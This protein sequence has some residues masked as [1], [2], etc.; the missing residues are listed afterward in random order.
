MNI[1]LIAPSHVPFVLGGAERLWHDLCHQI[2]E[3]TSNRADIINIPAPEGDFWEI[4]ESYNT[5]SRLNL[6]HFDMVIS[7]KNPC[8]MVQHP[9]HILYMLHPLRGVYDTYPLFHLPYQVKSKHTLVNKIAAACDAGIASDELFDELN[10]LKR[11][12]DEIIED[13]NIPSPF[14][15]KILHR[16]DSNALSSVKRIYTISNTVTGRAEYFHGKEVNGTLPPPSGLKVREGSPSAYLLTYSRLDQAKRI[17][18]II[19]GFKKTRVNLELRIAGEGPELQNLINLSAGDERIKFLGRLTDDSL[20]DQIAHARA[21]CF[22]PYQEDYG[23]VTIEALFAGKPVI[24]TSDAGGPLDFIV[25]GVN[26]YVA[27]PTPSSIGNAINNISQESDYFSLSAAAKKSVSHVRWDNLIARLLEQN[28]QTTINKKLIGVF[29]TYP[30]YPPKGGGQARVF[31]L[32]KE[33]EKEYCVHVVCLVD[34]SQCEETI[35]ISSNFKI[36][37]IPANKGFSEEDWKMYQSSGIPS[38][39]IVMSYFFDENSR[40][41]EVAKKLIKQADVLVAEQC[42]TYPLIYKYGE[43][44]PKVY[45]S[46]NVEY[47]LKEQMLASAKN[48]DKLLKYVHDAEFSA[49][50]SAELIIYCSKSDEQKMKEVYPEYIGHFSEVVKNGADLSSISYLTSNERKS[51]RHRLGINGVVAIFIASWHEPNIEAVRSL[52]VIAQKTPHIN[53]LIVGTV[54]DYFSN[55]P[56]KLSRNLHFTG[57]VTV[58]EKDILLQSADIAVNPML[59]GSGTNIKMFDYLAAGLPVVSTPVGARGIE[60]IHQNAFVC[61]LDE[62]PEYINRALKQKIKY[63]RRSFIQE[64]YSWKSVG[65]SY[66]SA[67]SKLL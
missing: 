26:G 6:N 63:S 67:I 1:A 43:S 50:N 41:I 56:E 20:V 22:T 48:K 46:Q 23:L 36:T 28:N 11:F 62:F 12:K 51:L 35:Q 39:D 25:N 27:E 9:N 7:G 2:N 10:E 47:V 37:N 49:C 5:F 32:C 29:S 34:G 66:R 44:K 33:L 60:D 8:W 17:D 58:E 55:N 40:Y 18:L 3:L 16:F 24:T 19:Q 30:I 13:I 31:Y 57:L 45:N 15:R 42:Y 54:G 53:Y 14:L 64:N 4:I 52:S 38:T 21:I 59:T 61:D 65:D